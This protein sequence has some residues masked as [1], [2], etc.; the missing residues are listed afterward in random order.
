MKK[1]VLIFTVSV[2]T[3]SLQAQTGQTYTQMFDSLFGNVPYST[4][5]SG[6]LYDRVVDFSNLGELNDTSSYTRFI[7]A[8][9]ELNR[10]V[11]NTFLNSK[12]SLKVDSLEE[13]LQNLSYIPIG[14]IN[15]K[16]DVIDT[17]AFHSGK[18]YESNG[19][20]YVNNAI[21]G[22]FSCL[23]HDLSNYLDYPVFF[24]IQNHKN[25]SSDEIIHNFLLSLQKNKI[26]ITKNIIL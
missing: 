24:I 18:L 14:I 2:A 12:F 19:L 23:N 9:S 4:V 15:A 13:R 16:Y 25:Q 22:S 1:L 17:N 7:Q 26:S 6:I 3:F 20:F 10:A 21:S 5:T 11:T 8:Y